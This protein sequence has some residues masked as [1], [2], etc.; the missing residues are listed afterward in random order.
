MALFRRVVNEVTTD[1]VAELLAASKHTN[2]LLGD[3][4]TVL[5][6]IRDGLK[7]PA[8]DHES[9]GKTLTRIVDELTKD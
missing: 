9:Q 4:L 6:E 3:L 8:T 7:E 5:E 1:D 2:E